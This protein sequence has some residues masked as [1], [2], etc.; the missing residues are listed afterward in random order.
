MKLAHAI[1]L[2]VA[3]L[4]LPAAAW[5]QVDLTHLDDHMSGTPTRVLVLGTVHLS[6]AKDFKATSLDG[7]IDKLARFEPQVI[8]IE[9]IGGEQCDMAARNPTI[10]GDDYCASA[11]AARKAT[12]LDIPRA[13]A[14]INAELA[15]WPAQPSAS[16]RRHLAALFLASS[17]PASALV[18]W[19]QLPPAERRMGDGLDDALVARLKELST[20][21]NE[22]YQI[23]ARLAAQLGL[24]R[25]YPVDDHTGDNMRVSDAKAFGRAVE[26]AWHADRTALDTEEKRERELLK[27]KDLL[28]LYRLVNQPTTQAMLADSN[29]GTTMRDPSPDRYPQMW[30]RGWEIRNLRI[31]ANVIE[32]VRERPGARVLSIIGASHKPWFESWLGQFQGVQMVDVEAVLK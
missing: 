8:T 7:L 25:V 3:A 31:V 14:G 13:I 19:L 10:Y 11:D 2:S 17:D 1:L 32:T 28:P 30:V 15:S 23:A 27:E 18:Q 9:A 29:A 26:K 6:Q 21:S 16:K 22:N 5:S 24:Q 4:A 12:G 20:A